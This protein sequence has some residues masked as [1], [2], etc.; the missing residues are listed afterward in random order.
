MNRKKTEIVAIVV[1]LLGMTCAILL[2]FLYER[3]SS[4]R[5]SRVITLTGVAATGTWT[6][7]NVNGWN[8]WRGDFP[9]ARVVL[10]VGETAV[11]RLKSADV[12]H[13]FY[14][15]ALA[16][17]PV[18]VEPGHV[19][20]LRLKPTEEGVFEYY[21]TMVCGMPHFGMRGEIIVQGRSGAASAAALPAAG[22]YWQETP[23]N[24]GASL[25]ERGSWLFRQKGCF[26]CHGQEG[27]G[28]VVNWNYVKGTVPALNSLAEKLMLFDPEDVNAIVGELERG[29]D[30]E[31]IADAAPIPRYNVF[32]AQYHS[33][34]DLIH[35]GNPPGKKDP[36]KPEPPLEMLAWGQRLSEVDI[37]AIIAYL[38]TLRPVVDTGG[39]P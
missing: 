6:D 10:H 23:P 9:P 39:R 33:V 16:A 15:P 12:A 27:T 20:E 4:S 38:L 14:V 18:T 21:C 24:P 28:G 29:H 5:G 36:L 19:V 3:R 1:T 32:L 34:R 25:V 8:Y 26:T 31:K 2:P 17:E 13:K 11:L 7:K 37:D 35:R 22:R 30:L